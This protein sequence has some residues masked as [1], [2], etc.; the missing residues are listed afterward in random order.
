MIHIINGTIAE[1]LMNLMLQGKFLP[2][3]INLWSN[4]IPFVAL[5]VFGIILLGIYIWTE[6]SLLPAL[7]LLTY[8]AIALLPTTPAEIKQVM[9]P[10]LAKPLLYALIALSF[11]PVIVNLILR[12]RGY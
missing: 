8:W 6:D 4:F 10:E 12:N 5:V 7:L 11:T 9:L 3:T 1:N 2:L